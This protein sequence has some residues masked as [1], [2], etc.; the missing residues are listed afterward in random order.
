MKKIITVFTLMTTI[1]LGAIAQEP[2]AM[3]HKGMHKGQG[4]GMHA[5]KEALQTLNL[6]ESQQKQIR[7]IRK[8]T[9]KEAMLL[10]ENRGMTLEQY[11][12]RRAAL[13]RQEKSR[14]ESVLTQEQKNRLATMKTE[15]EQKMKER[16]GRH[17]E[18]MKANLSL[19]DDQAQKMTA[20]REKNRQSIKQI[21]ENDQLGPDSKQLAIRK[22][23]DE[24]AS[25]RKKILTEE[26]IRKMDELKQQHEGKRMHKRRMDVRK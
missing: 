21:R 23:K 6:S 3:R 18:Q 24:A 11:D 17:F 22:I 16:Q 1:S 10:K 8:Q 7:D 20:L 12:Q 15:R 4:S 19:T 26:Q 9:R 5:K 25:E 13:K 2:G 14:V